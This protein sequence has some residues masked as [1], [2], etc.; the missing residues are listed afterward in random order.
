[1][2]LCSVAL[3]CVVLF[4]RACIC[5]CVC[6]CAYVDVY[7]CVCMCVCKWMVICRK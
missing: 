2:L 3:S 5:V 6:V 7:V 1:M 4:P